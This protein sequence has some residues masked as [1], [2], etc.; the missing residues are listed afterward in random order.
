MMSK[1]VR[2]K[3]HMNGGGGGG[4]ETAKPFGRRH[5]KSFSNKNSTF[6]PTT[7]TKGLGPDSDHR[8]IEGSTRKRAKT[9]SVMS[10]EVPRAHRNR[11]TPPPPVVRLKLIRLPSVGVL[12]TA[13]DILRETLR[14][15]RLVRK[16]EM[17][18]KL[19]TKLVYML[20]SGAQQAKGLEETRELKTLRKQLE[21]MGAMGSSSHSTPFPA[22]DH[23]ASDD[24]GD[25]T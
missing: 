7:T 14:I 12:R 13:E 23:D 22:I 11:R 20:S 15:Y 25:G 5:I 24:Q 21:A 10:K 19:G 6:T 1:S 8:P 3:R 2:G 18:E 16:G 9:S 4:A 17:S